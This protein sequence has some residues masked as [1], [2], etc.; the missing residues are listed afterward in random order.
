LLIEEFS[1]VLGRC[2]SWIN[3]PGDSGSV[4]HYCLGLVFLEQTT[5]DGQCDGAR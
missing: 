4:A 3:V 2:S 1:L 5:A